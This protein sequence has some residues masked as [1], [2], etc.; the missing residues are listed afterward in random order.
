MVEFDEV[1][2]YTYY[3]LGGIAGCI[4]LCFLKRICSS[5]EGWRRH[6]ELISETRRQTRA[7][8]DQNRIRKMEVTV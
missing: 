8:E 1:K 3:T 5:C 6:R 4:G 7:I 2:L